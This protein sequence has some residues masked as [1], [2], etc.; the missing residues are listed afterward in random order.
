LADREGI[1]QKLKECIDPLNNTQHPDGIVNIATGEIGS[2]GINVHDAV[3]IGEAMLV[4]FETS[5][6][7]L[8]IP[9]KV[10]TMAASAKSNS[11]L[12]GDK[13]GYDL[14]AIYS[15]VIGLL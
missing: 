8:T 12:V 7:L 14:N 9:K 5:W 10:T 11:D 6:I 4:E 2:T 13:T 3:R 1:R 15:R